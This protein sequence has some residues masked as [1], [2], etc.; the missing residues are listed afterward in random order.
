[1]SISDVGHLIMFEGDMTGNCPLCQ[2]PL[3]H[4][5]YDRAVEVLICKERR[6]LPAPGT[7]LSPAT[8]ELLRLGA[9]QLGSSEADQ[10]EQ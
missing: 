2:Q 10:M 8:A 7:P 1:M 4:E 3:Q 9:M 5:C 6:P